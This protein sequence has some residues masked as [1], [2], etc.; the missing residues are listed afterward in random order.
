[1]RTSRERLLRLAAE[2][3]LVRLYRALT[4]LGS[5]ITVMNTGAHPDDEHNGMLATLRHQ[6]GARIII[7]CST[8]GEGGQNTL[9]PER[10]GA[11]GVIRSRELEEAARIIDADVC[12]LGHGQLDPVH[13]FGFSKS[14][15][16][17]L[18]R[19]GKDRIIDRLV[20]AYR[21]FRPDIVIPTFLDVPGQHGHHRA[22]TEAAETA[23][24]LSADPAYITEGL[25]PWT[26]TKFYLPAWSGG[27]DYYDDEVPPPAETTAVI[28]QGS[29]PA[30]G[31]S[32]AR[33]GEVSRAF[34]ATQNMGY[35]D[36]AT[37]R[38][39][40]HLAK[41]EPEPDVFAG[42]PQ[43]LSDLGDAPELATAEKAMEEARA[44]F[45]N[46]EKM[47]DALLRAREALLAV[48]VTDQHSHRIRRKI[49]ELDAAILLAADIDVIACV[50]DTDI[51]A[52]E[53]VQI[54][55]ECRSGPASAI[56][57]QARG[58]DRFLLPEPMTLSEK[59]SL[60]IGTRA[61]AQARNAFYPDWLSLGG[62]GALWFEG[63]AELRGQTIRF[64]LD[65]DVPVNILP[66][67]SVELSTEALLLKGGHAANSI[68]LSGAS[69]TDMIALVETPAALDVTVKGQTIELA[70]SSLAPGRYQL[71][72][73]L[74]G[75]P[76][77]R[78]T[79]SAHPH[80][81]RTAFISP[82]T[83]D[84]LSLDLEV[85]S[86]KIGF[87]DGGA[88]AVGIWLRRMGA[89]VTD[90]DAE[91]L[92]GPLAKF[93]TIVVGIFAFGT[94][95]DLFAARSKLRTYVEN[96][97]HLV[98]LYH[99]P[100]DGWDTQATPPRAVTIGTP[101]LRWRVSNPASEVEML[102][103]DHPLLAGPNRIAAEDFDGWDKE[104]GLYF[105]SKWDPAYE[106][107]L[108]MHDPGETPLN[109][110]LISARIGAGRHTHSSLVLHH[111]MD[112]LVPGAFRLMAN[113]LQAA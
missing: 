4:R 89:D 27:G 68:T 18:E 85:P 93:D 90:L 46:N 29:D 102:L 57:L 109:G 82:V 31:L 54:A 28:A 101:S 95:P 1:M 5:T 104:R 88:D 17:T 107:L 69:E 86:T 30:T 73:T 67:K 108:A 53:P 9:G 112:K 97:G 92:A 70:A 59:L 75:A 20:R 21:Q 76:A 61:D 64:R 111:Q 100:T 40:L 39:P 87:V 96:G 78:V 7:A 81:G 2:P 48:E 35:W 44:A 80:V 51:V 16:D 25:E 14:G 19:W 66:Q 79:P 91:A 38:W 34:H 15:P 12:W 10:V 52:G 71:P 33:L 13:D 103:P 110:S 36:E 32:F 62:N 58:D 47:L 65:T 23:I 24:G 55:L 8:R 22:M 49:E 99:R 113:L 43:S 98:T 11:L 45:P 105:A 41:G 26:V 74:N 63:E 77:H 50:A 94:R 72:I 106:A 83:L 60:E 3:R 6:H 37:N 84:L 42:L 56:R